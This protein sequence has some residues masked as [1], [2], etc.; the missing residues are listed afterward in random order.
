MSG[1]KHLSGRRAKDLEKKSIEEVISLSI[2]TVYQYL[3][4]G[5]SL[6]DR[7]RVGSSFALKMMPEKVDATVQRVL[8]APERA[9]MLAELRRVLNAPDV[10]E[11]DAPPTA[12]DTVKV[13]TLTTGSVPEDATS[14]LP[15]FDTTNAPAEPPVLDE[16][17]AGAAP[18]L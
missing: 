1:R 2:H 6:R 11:V 4:S 7:A 9:A 12:V 18:S 17:Q 14:A 5:A 3:M 10:Y 8:T 15:S 13:T 16:P